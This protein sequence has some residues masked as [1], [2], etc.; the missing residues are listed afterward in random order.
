MLTKKGGQRHRLW[1]KI[2]FWAMFIVAITAVVM[3]IMRSGLFLLLVGIF[4]FYLSFSGYRVLYRK[5]PTDRAHWLDWSVSGVTA[6][7]S[8]ALFGYGVVQL[9]GGAS[10]GM[11]ALVFGAAGSVT[12]GQDL[13]R[14]VRPPKDKRAWW[15]LHMQGFLGAYIATVTAFSAVNLTFLPPVARWLWPTVVGS[16]GIALWTRY[17][18]QRFARSAKR[19]APPLAPE[20]AM[21]STPT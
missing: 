8:V 5:R 11:V 6:L 17:Y 14:Y 20:K 4:S 2:Y 10:F 19:T 12:A 18:R 16:I 7:G 13:Y 3:S 15:F 21:T 1:G 9:L